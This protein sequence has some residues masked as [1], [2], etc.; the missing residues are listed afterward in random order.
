MNDAKSVAD[1]DDKYLMAPNRRAV[2]FGRNV[3]PLSRGEEIGLHS[4]APREVAPAN[5]GAAR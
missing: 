5:R 2:W 3:V 1:G 4:A